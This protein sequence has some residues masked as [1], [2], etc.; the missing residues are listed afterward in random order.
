M[1]RDFNISAEEALITHEI[2]QRLRF[3]SEINSD[4]I[5]LSKGATMIWTALKTFKDIVLLLIRTIRSNSM[6]PI[7]PV[8]RMKGSIALQGIVLKLSP[9]KRKWTKEFWSQYS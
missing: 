2:H 5:F 8:V 6:H 1:T 9:M 7:F 4:A 3:H